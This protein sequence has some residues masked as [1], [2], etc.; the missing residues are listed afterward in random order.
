MNIL[1]EIKVG[2]SHYQKQG[3]SYYF[4]RPNKKTKK[5][6]PGIYTIQQDPMGQIYLEGMSAM[7]DSLIRLPDFTSEKVIKEVEKFWTK[8]TK[9]KF[10]KRQL[11]YKRGIILHGLPGTGKSACVSQL[12]EAEVKQGGIVFFSP[13][14]GMLQYVVKCIREIQG[15]IRCLV[16]WEE[17]DDLIE[18]NESDFLS[19]LDGEMQIDNVVYI[20]T[21][22]YLD[23]IPNR[24]KNRPSRFASIIEV[25]LPNEETRKVY[26]SNKIH[27]DDNIDIDVWAK[28][29]EGFTI[30][31][32]K[33]LI[34]SVLCLD[35]PF[36]E[37][38]DR[39][40][41]F[42]YDENK[43]ESPMQKRRRLAQMKYDRLMGINKRDIEEF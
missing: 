42:Q 4:G 32:I 33:D 5:L 7:T 13:S 39:L 30:D 6:E 34:I 24:F 25:G 8:E 21:T 15:D 11:V 35:V 14:P 23:R 28:A 29:T 18:A 17:F 20:G 37:A 16:V 12:M 36:N 40:K 2:V 3:N 38:L 19:L 22:N 10:T 31:H 41:D 27:A 9:A 1:N 43:N 26:L